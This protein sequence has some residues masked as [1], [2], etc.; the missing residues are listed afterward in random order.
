MLTFLTQAAISGD[1]H[2]R[3]LD[4]KEYN[5]N[6]IGEFYLIVYRNASFQSQ[7]RFERAKNSTGTY[8][9]FVGGFLRIKKFLLYDSEYSKKEVM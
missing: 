7:V 4:G 6:G 3:T 2:I 5:F 1:P 9:I 8:L